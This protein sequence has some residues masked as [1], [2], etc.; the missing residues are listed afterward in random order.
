M[1]YLLLIAGII[2]LSAV[3]GHFTMGAKDFLNN[4]K[5]PACLIY[6]MDGDDD[7]EKFYT[8]GFKEMVLN[9]K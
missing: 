4:N 3:A 9:E 5:Y 7:L 2:S 1:N 6:D 8:N